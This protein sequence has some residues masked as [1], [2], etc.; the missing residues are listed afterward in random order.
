MGK[1]VLLVHCYAQNDA[2][3]ASAHA[4]ALV[5]FGPGYFDDLSIRVAFLFMQI[6][7]YRAADAL[8]MVIYCASTHEYA[9]ICA[10][11]HEY[12]HMYARIPTLFSEPN[13][14]RSYW[15]FWMQMQ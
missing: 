14:E 1:D 2:S 4:R 12:T 6:F 15:A 13:V 8:R 11:T 7:A 3:S 9:H 10:I 5:C